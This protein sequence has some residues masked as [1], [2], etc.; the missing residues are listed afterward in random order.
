MKPFAWSY[1]RLSSY[2]LCPRKFWYDQNNKQPPGEEN[3]YGLDVHKSFELYLKGKQSLP[4]D[5]QHHGKAI[6]KVKQTATPLSEQRLCVNKDFEPVGFFDNDAW[7]RVVVDFAGVNPK[8]KSVIIVDWKTGKRR[9]VWEQ[10]YIQAAV[11]NC[12]DLGFKPNA[13]L[14]GFYWTKDREFDWEHFA[15]D[16]IP[17]VWNELM[18][19]VEQ[20]NDA[21][22]N[23]EF[24]ERQNFLCAKYCADKKCKF[25]GI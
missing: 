10:L 17:G 4:L 19:R 14:L 11:L 1:S 22:N 23:K 3:S 16:A 5:L 8:K 9:P 13:Y 24:P 18:P 15:P 25:N 20:F 6:D 21:W 2:E 12:Y 7:L